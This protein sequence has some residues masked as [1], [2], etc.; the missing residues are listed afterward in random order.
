MNMLE[1][2]DLC[3]CMAAETKVD[4]LAEAC[5]AVRRIPEQFFSGELKRDTTD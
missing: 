2:F 3:D 5:A 4:A 1:L